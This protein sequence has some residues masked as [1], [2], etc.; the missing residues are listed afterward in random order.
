M[1]PASVALS[2]SLMS[3]APMAALGSQ[4]QAQSAAREPKVLIIGIDGVR[5]DALQAAE[6]PAIDALI[7]NGCVAFDAS[8][9]AY[10]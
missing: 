7:A 6:T 4:Q 1:N 3:L 5:P 9:S 10:T 2:W 8:A